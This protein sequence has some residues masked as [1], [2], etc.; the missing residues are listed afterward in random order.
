MQDQGRS[1]SRDLLAPLP[2]A[3]AFAHLQGAS[4]AVQRLL[5]DVDASSQ[6]GHDLWSV[7]QAILRAYQEL[8]ACARSGG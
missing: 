8:V 7:E 1:L 5:D 2:K 3:A 4:A 6:I